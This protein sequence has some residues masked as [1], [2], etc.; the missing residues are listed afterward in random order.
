MLTP[1]ILVIDDDKHL[2]E[3]IQLYLEAQGFVVYTAF[4]GFHAHPMATIHKPSLIIM[5]V[6]MPTTNGVEA[7]LKLRSDAQTKTIP[8]I[9]LTGGRVGPVSFPWLNS[10]SA[11]RTSK[12]PCL[13]KIFSLM[14]RHDIPNN[15]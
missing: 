7:L 6:D 5:D 15:L 8:V 11:C 12:N 1:K 4:D 13:S 14:V 3:I 2:V 10:W 9:L